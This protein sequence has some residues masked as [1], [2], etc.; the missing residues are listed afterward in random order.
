MSHLAILLL[1]M[2]LKQMQSDPKDLSARPRSLWP[3]SQE[4]GCEDNLHV[5][6]WMNR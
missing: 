4:Q 1:G 2:E 6:L 3:Y 5:H